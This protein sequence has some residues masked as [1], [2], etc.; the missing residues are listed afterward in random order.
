MLRNPA[1]MIHSL[2]GQYLYDPIEQE[3]DLAKAWELSTARKAGRQVPVLC[4]CP[5]LL[6]YDEVAYYGE[7]TSIS[8]GNRCG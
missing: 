6:Y 3:P 8:R 5:P 1:D 7:C 2:H 4:L